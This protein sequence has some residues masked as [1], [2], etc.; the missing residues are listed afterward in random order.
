MMPLAGPV[1]ATVAIFSFLGHYNDFMGPLIYLSDNNTFTL[2]LGL[3][4]FQGRFGDRWPLV[5]AASTVMIV[6]PII[7]FFFAQRQFIRG[8]QLSGLAGR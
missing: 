5:M 2:A 8:I 4:M 6:P 1:I 7:L 3:R